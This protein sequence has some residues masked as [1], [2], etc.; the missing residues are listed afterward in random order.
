MRNAAVFTP[1]PIGPFGVGQRAGG[2]RR[3]LREPCSSLAFW[4][5]RRF[6]L[7][8]APLGSIATAHS[9]SRRGLVQ[10]LGLVEA[11]PQ[12]D[13]ELWVVGLQGECGARR[14]D[15]VVVPAQVAGAAADALVEHGHAWEACRRASV[16][17]E[18]VH[19]LPRVDKEVAGLVDDL[20]EI[21][22]AVR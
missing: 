12:V 13:D 11:P 7:A 9:G 19:V 20:A 17:F 14:R 15:G 18:S 4:Q 10:A 16:E 8:S 22:R 6:S 2:R 1:G 5:V 21:L 3:R